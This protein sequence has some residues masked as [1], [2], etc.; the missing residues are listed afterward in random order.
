MK[1]GFLRSVFDFS[2]AMENAKWKV[3]VC[4]PFFTFHWQLTT[5]KAAV[6]LDLS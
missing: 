5:S 2:L 1:S 6:Y 3:D 4:N